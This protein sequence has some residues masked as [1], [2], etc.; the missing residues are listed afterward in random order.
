MGETWASIPLSPATGEATPKRGILNGAVEVHV[1]TWSFVAS[2]KNWVDEDCETPWII[3]VSI[4]KASLIRTESI[5]MRKYCCNT[6]V[7][8][9]KVISTVM[10]E[11]RT[12]AVLETKMEAMCYFL[13]WIRT[14]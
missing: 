5:G 6:V 12:S 1:M 4:L 2:V 7:T 13:W 14:K 9:T 3:V 10:T 8:T 11:S